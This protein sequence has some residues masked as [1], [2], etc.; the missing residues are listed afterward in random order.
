MFHFYCPWFG[1]L[2]PLPWLI[3]KMIPKTNSG[4]ELQFPALQRLK[5]AFTSYQVVST[6]PLS[7]QKILLSFAWAMFVLTLMQPERTEQVSHVKHQGHDILLAV[8]TSASMQALDFSTQFK[9]VSRLDVTKEVVGRFVMGRQGDRVGLITF[10][11]HPYLHVPLT[12]DTLSVSQ[13]LNHI[14][15]GMAGNGTAVGD[16]IGLGVRTLRNRPEGSRVLVLLTDGEDNSSRIPPLEAAKL[17]KEYGIR[18]YTVGVGRKGA[19][20]FPSRFGGFGMAEFPLDEKLLKNIAETTGGHYFLA[21]DEAAL[22][23]IYEQIDRLEKTEADVITF[24]VRNPLY[25]I[26]LGVAMLLILCLTF[27]QRRLVHGF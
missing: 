16:A 20:P 14:T 10:G 6:S 17:A 5:E 15:S 2:F 22:K 26:P 25:Q 7:W 11:E 19:V 21:A 4:L 23:S 27:Y 18:I 24:I 12:L 8:D 3:G 13:M 1:L 9:T